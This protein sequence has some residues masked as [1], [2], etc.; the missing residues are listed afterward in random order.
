MQSSMALVLAGGGS[1]GAVQVGMLQA[2]VEA[3]VTFDLVVGASVGA[4]NGAYFAAR[5]T[6]EGVAELTQ[7]WLGL[8]QADVFPFSLTD[9]LGALLH[10]R[11]HLLQTAALLR[12]IRRTLPVQRIEETQLPLHIVATDLLSGA[13]VLLSRGDAA[14]ALLAS[15]AIPLVF[16]AVLREDQVLV[17]GGV[18]S[19]TPIASAVALGATRIVVLPTGFGCACKEP[20]RGLVALALHTL[21]LMSMRQLVR[22]IELHAPSASIHVV[23]PLCPQAV[24]LFD[25]SHTAELL[26]RAQRQTRK[27]LNAGGLERSGVPGALEAH[28]HGDMGM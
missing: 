2:L 9:T 5:P 8:H 16:P 15:T 28:H 13:E 23:A 17:D 11:G 12:L 26:Q 6:A 21:N 24:S 25:F 1:L 10:Q 20:P 27:W 19:N 14:Q 4:I 3:G 7:I 22:D 18:A